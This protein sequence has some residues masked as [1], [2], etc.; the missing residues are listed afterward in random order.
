MS[1]KE[2]ISITYETFTQQIE[3]LC[4]Y[5]QLPYIDAIVHWCE[6]NGV[7]VEYAANMI[8]RNQVMKLKVQQEAETLN[9]MKK[10]ARLS[11]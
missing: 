7:E 4:Q 8:K 3:F 11:I 10:T 6:V 9:F 5:K 2:L 1:E